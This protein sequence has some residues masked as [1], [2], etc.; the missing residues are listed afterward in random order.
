MEL[1]AVLAVLALI[2]GLALAGF[3]ADSRDN[4]NWKAS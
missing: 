4:C 3:G 1:I 2:A